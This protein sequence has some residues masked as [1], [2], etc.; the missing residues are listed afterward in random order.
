MSLEERVLSLLQKRKD[1]VLSGKINS[2]PSPFVRF[3]DDFLGIEQGK[4]YLV[5]SSTKGAKTQFASYLFIFHTLLYSYYH[6]EQIR[7][8]IFYYPLEETAEDVL[9]RF[10]SYILYIFTGGKERV[11]PIDLKSTRADKPVSSEVLKLLGSD[12]YTKLVSHFENNVIFSSTSNPTGIYHEC[13]K[14]AEDNGTVYTKPTKVKDDETGMIKEIQKFDYYE[15]ADVD[16]YRIIFVDHASLI[17]TEKG[18]PLKQSVD[19]LSEYFVLL[20]NR[21]GFSPVL[22]QQ[23]AFQGESLEAVKENK[24]RPTIAN[25]SDSKYP[26]RDKPKKSISLIQSLNPVNLGK[27]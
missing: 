15:S 11:S 27:P 18:M 13:R 16:E 5:T 8:K 20:R 14:Y 7:V 9:I 22:I 3:R 24:V 10:M 19:K 4:Y 1:K 6:P 17:S 23:Q 25:L 21:Y 12:K 26:S 2:I